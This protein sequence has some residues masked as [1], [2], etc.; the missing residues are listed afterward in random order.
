[1]ISNSVH[2]MNPFIIDLQVMVSIWNRVVLNMQKINELIPTCD[3]K[4]L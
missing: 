1:M 3:L 2:M 4:S